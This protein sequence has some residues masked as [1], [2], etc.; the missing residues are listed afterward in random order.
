MVGAE[1]VYGY[2]KEE[3]VGASSYELIATPEAQKETQ[4]VIASVFQGKTFANM[5]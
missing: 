4:N 3:A 5:L 2:T 1:Q